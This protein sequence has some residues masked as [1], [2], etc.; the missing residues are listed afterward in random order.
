MSFYEPVDIVSEAGAKVWLIAWHPLNL[1][2]TVPAHPRGQQ[3][4]DP[5]SA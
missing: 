5:A 4:A 2:P 3:L 1:D